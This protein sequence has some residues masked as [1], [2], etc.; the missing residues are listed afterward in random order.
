MS[1]KLLYK[2]MN[3]DELVV[4]SQQ[5]DLRA[6]EEKNEKEFPEMQN[7]LRVG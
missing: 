1:E 5:E 4:L 6:L 3:L 7:A 2:K